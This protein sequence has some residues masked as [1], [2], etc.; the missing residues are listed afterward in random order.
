MVQ[1]VPT[2]SLATERAREDVIARLRE[3]AWVFDP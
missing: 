2:L 1:S 3:D